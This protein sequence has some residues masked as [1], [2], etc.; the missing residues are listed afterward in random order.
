MITLDGALRRIDGAI[1]ELPMVLTP[2]TGAVG[3]CLGEDIIAPFNVP[4]FDNSAMDGIAV[5][6]FDLK[7]HGPWTLP[8]QAVI[9]AGDSINEPLLPKN[10]VKIMTGAPMLPGADTVI[11]IEDIQ[12]DDNKAIITERPE[13]GKFVRP[14]GDDISKGHQLFRKGDVLGVIDI[15]ALASI[16]LSEVEVVS[17]VREPRGPCLNPI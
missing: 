3:G 7:G 5:R 15:G 1:D 13:K 14:A 11:P 2:L 10:V 8:I 17:I 6:V 12:I 16:G 4:D 9:A